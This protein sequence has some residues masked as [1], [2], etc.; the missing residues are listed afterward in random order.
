MLSQLLLALVLFQTPKPRKARMYE[1]PVFSIRE[2]QIPEKQG[3]WKKKQGKAAIGEC[4]VSK[5][6]VRD[7]P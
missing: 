5:N 2:N 6:E 7:F 4:I 1:R 3:S